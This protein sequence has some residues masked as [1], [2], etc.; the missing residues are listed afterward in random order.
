VNDIGPGVEGWIVEHVVGTAPPL[1]F[2][3]IAGGYSNRTYLVTDAAGCRSVLRCPPAHGVPTGSH[4]VVREH[5]I[6]SALPSTSVPTPQPL[7]VCTDAASD[8]YAA[9][10]GF[11]LESVPFHRALAYWRLAAIA[12]GIKHRYELQPATR[13]TSGKAT[14]DAGD[15]A[16]DP[17]HLDRR[18]RD[19]AELADKH[20]RSVDA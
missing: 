14:G 4:G 6:L 1:H 5:R 2:E 16:T 19:A 3:R 11:D 12:K 8:R 10:T 13:T 9:Q 18:V 20:L 7:G 17:G 15:D